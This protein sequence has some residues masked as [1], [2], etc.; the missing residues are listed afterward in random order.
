MLGAGL[1]IGLNVLLIPYLG[2][3]GS[4][5]ATLACYFIMSVVSYVVGQ[6]HYYIPYEPLKIGFY[7]LVAL[8]IYGVNLFIPKYSVATQIL[9]GL[10]SIGLFLFIF[11]RNEK[12]IQALIS[13]Y[14]AKRKR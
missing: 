9:T 7:I 14:Y 10:A 13:R 6:R 11:I 12:D 5:W 1:T 3:V 4:A 8:C 2:Y